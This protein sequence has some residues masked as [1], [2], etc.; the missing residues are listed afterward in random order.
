MT[1]IHMGLNN[2]NNGNSSGDEYEGE[3][4]DK[5][6]G[7][8]GKVAYMMETIYTFNMYDV[9][10]KQYLAKTKIPILSWINESSRGF[11]KLGN[12]Y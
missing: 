7:G 9:E 10:S 11:G 1:Y 8:K 4:Y 6:G 3:G 2:V 5:G 12:S